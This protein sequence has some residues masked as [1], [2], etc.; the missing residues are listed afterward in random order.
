MERGRNISSLGEAL[1]NSGLVVDHH[2][3]TSR[4]TL[5]PFHQRARS[6]GQPSESFDRLPS[7]EGRRTPTFEDEEVERSPSPDRLKRFLDSTKSS[8]SKTRVKNKLNLNPVESPSSSVELRNGENHTSL[9]SPTSLRNSD[10][11]TTSRR[12]HPMNISSP[13]R[14]R[15]RAASTHSLPGPVPSVSWN[16][17]P[18]K[19][20][21]KYHKVDRYPVQPLQS[22]DRMESFEYSDNMWSKTWF[23]SSKPVDRR[24]VQQLSITFDEMLHDLDLEKGEKKLETTQVIEREQQVFDILLN[25]IIRQ[26]YV[27]CA[28][29]GALLHKVSTRYKDL[30][31]KV[32]SLLAQMQ[33]EADT[34]MDAN[35]SLRMLLEKLMEEKEAS[36]LRLEDQNSTLEHLQNQIYVLRESEI[37][38]RTQ[39]ERATRERDDSLAT[40]IR[41]ESMISNNDSL[42]QSL[43]A[44]EREN[45]MSLKHL[46]QQL[47]EDA[48]GRLNEFEQ[49]A[50]LTERKKSLLSVSSC[51]E[52]W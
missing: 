6:R 9:P 37:D 45:Q 41:L 17:P 22:K 14:P 42:I 18:S 31:T 26:V 25:E 51:D 49:M 32:P 20:P 30:F 48:L 39:L 40:N 35:K 12:Y 24:E 50:K 46:T 21:E 27:E 29:R 52:D 43:E 4:T 16:I 5:P 10:E 28:D 36:D 23:P 38:A 3:D 7:R 15:L 11:P 1:I 44:R 2:S 34:L 47:A 33:D 8:S 13:E 19:I